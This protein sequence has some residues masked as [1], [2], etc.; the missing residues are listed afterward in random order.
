M[1]FTF[2][3]ALDPAL[4][5]D[6]SYEAGR[7]VARRQNTV[8][9]LEA[10]QQGQ[11][12]Q[13]SILAQQQSQQVAMAHSDAQEQRRLAYSHY[14]AK[15]ARQH[16]IDM[17]LLGYDLDVGKSRDQFARQFAFTKWEK[18]QRALDD[19]NREIIDADLQYRNWAMQNAP[20]LIESEQPESLGN[21]PLSM[22]PPPNVREPEWHVP[23]A[24]KG[25]VQ[26]YL[27]AVDGVRISQLPF[28][29]QRTQLL[30]KIQQGDPGAI[31][32][33]LQQG[34]LRWTPKQ[35]QDIAEIQDAMS[36]VDS[37]NRLKP[38]E[39]AAAQRMLMMRLQSIRPVMAPQEQRPVSVDEQLAEKIRPF[40]NP[41]TGRTHTVK[42]NSKGE[43]EE[44]FAQTEYKD[45]SAV[46][47]LEKRKEFTARFN[48]AHKLLTTYDENG[49][50]IAPDV[51]DVIAHL[52]TIDQ[53]YE[54]LQ[55]GG[56]P[57]ANNQTQLPV[58]RT[59]QEAAQ[60][61]PGTYFLDNNGIK[62]LR[63]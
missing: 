58:M 54:Q 25:G 60:L 24:V 34:I 2:N 49:V 1:G 27:R 3:Y 43:P 62:R 10:R 39:K 50:A 61:P 32:M 31:D 45:D 53:A 37:D 15:A 14:D 11:M 12:Q 48:S 20:H 9:S 16:Q 6:A 63:P 30:E 13:A 17:A 38:M 23:D 55:G 5:A 47:E 21:A 29:S 42:I 51:N 52:Q 46:R 36:R 19:Q 57:Q 41:T 56:A 4:A 7:S 59:P 8:R 22:Q 40:Y 44:M 26:N 28:Q 35:K 33:G 18:E